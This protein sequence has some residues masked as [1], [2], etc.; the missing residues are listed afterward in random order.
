MNRTRLFQHTTLT[1][2]ALAMLLVPTPRLQ[3][4]TSNFLV[5]PQ[6]GL[7]LDNPGVTKTA[8]KKAKP[9]E[10]AAEKKATEIT[11][12]GETLFDVKAGLAT[13]IKEV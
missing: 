5:T 9:A 1:A 8:D 13:F 2:L 4:Q 6:T 7:E 10:A 12:T 3:A 11:C